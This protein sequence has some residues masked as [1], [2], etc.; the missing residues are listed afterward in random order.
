M[1]KIICFL[2]LFISPFL[3]GETYIINL[4]NKYSESILVKE[5]P[6]STPVFP[7]V[8]DNSGS[9]CINTFDKVGWIDRTSD[10]CNGVRALSSNP[11][12]LVLRSI[13]GYRME[14][15]T[16]PEGY[17]W[18]S[19]QDY[20]SQIGSGGYQY[21]GHCGLSGYPVSQDGLSQREISFS[22]TITN[23]CRT[24]SGTHEGSVQCGSVW[25]YPTGW[26]GIVVIRDET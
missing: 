26:F 11:N 21:Y 2:S 1:K 17:S 14:N 6:E 25:D 7:E 10:T 5:L 23:N 22:N 8:V 15:P 3:L 13:T 12:I 18:L 19:V 9:S 20:S 16:I 4:N 24:H